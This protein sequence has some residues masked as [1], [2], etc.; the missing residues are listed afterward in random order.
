MTERNFKTHIRQLGQKVNYNL[1]RLEKG[2]FSSVNRK[3]FTENR[4]KQL[5]S[6]IVTVVKRYNEGV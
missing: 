1:R 2:N 4:I 3:S 5:Q 6:Q